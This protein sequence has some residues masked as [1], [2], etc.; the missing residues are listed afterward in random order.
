[1]PAISRFF[2]IIIRMFAEV[3][4]LLRSRKR[5]TNTLDR[6]AWSKRGP[7]FIMP[8]CWT[9]GGACNPV[10]H[11][12]RSRHCGKLVFLR[13]AESSARPVSPAKHAVV[14]THRRGGA[15]HCVDGVC[16]RKMPTRQN[17]AGLEPR[18]ASRCRPSHSTRSRPS[19]N[20]GN[21]AQ[22]CEPS[23]R[24]NVLAAC[25]KVGTADALS[26]TTGVIGPGCARLGPTLG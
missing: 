7:R 17:A 13:H 26:M 11:H 14:A 8:S 16:G 24:G 6:V 10:S 22:P 20:T 18:E 23:G 3:G 9:T 5:A 21:S 4:A 19:L 2:G 25:R 12:S 1:M 15:A